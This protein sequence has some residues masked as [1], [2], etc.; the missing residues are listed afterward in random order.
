VSILQEYKKYIDKFNN[1]VQ[2]VRSDSPE[3]VSLAMVD[4]QGIKFRLGQI[5][6][7][8]ESEFNINFANA[9]TA[10]I[11]DKLA[12]AKAKMEIELKHGISKNHIE[13]AYKDLDGLVQTLK[14][15]LAVLSLDY[16][17]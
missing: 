8:L 14:K 10:D 11:T 15:R 13:R 3:L 2:S 16:N 4:L 12:E 7:E 9:K 5:L 1:Y 17:G 6:A